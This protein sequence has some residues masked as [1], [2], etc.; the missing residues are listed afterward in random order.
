MIFERKGNWYIEG[1]GRPYATKTEAEKAFGV[2]L[3]LPEVREYASLDEAL[4]DQDK[5]DLDLYEE[6]LIA[7]EE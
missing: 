2:S 5:D 6:E 7:E 3:P 1:K 4:A